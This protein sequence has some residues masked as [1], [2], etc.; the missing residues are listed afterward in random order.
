MT[1]KQFYQ[2]MEE[3]TL[4]LCGEVWVPAETVEELSSERLIYGDNLQ[5]LT[6]YCRV[7]YNEENGCDGCPMVIAGDGC[8]NDNSSYQKFQNK[9]NEK[10]G[11]EKSFDVF[12]SSMEE[13]VNEYNDT[14]LK[15]LWYSGKQHSLIGSCIMVLKDGTKIE[16]TNFTNTSSHCTNW[17][18]ITLIATV[19]NMDIQTIYSKKIG[20]RG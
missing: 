10:Y 14:S 13:L 2:K 11:V 18:D 8:K 17:E 5:Y 6:P 9:M 15:Y 1:T 4:R 7:F 19:R 3:I 20:Y 16:Y 12:I